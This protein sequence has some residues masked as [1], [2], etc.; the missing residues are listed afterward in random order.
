MELYL[1]D[2]SIQRADIL[3]VVPGVWVLDGEYVSE[4][5]Q[6]LREGSGLPTEGSLADVCEHRYYGGSSDGGSAERTH[7]G[8]RE[9]DDLLFAQRTDGPGREGVEGE[10]APRLGRGEF[11]MYHPEYRD[12]RQQGRLTRKLLET[13]VWRIPY[14]YT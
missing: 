10:E 3:N 2:H 6:R 11:S 4:Q 14:R 12:L 1:G 7:G 13:V 5:E 8:A 9:Q